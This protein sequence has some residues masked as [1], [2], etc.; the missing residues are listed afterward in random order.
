V[1]YDA[2]SAYYLIGGSKKEYKNSGAMSLLMWKAIQEAK[3]NDLAE[4]NFEGSSIPSIEQYLRGFGGKLHSFCRM[5][6]RDSS[7]L[8][9]VR[10]LNG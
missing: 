2:N 8:A 9:I 3:A 5:T 7:S 4:F 1:I 10:Q 6:K